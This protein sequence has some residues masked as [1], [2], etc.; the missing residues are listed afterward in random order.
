MNYMLILHWKIHFIPLRCLF[1]VNSLNRIYKYYWNSKKKV[2]LIL[3]SFVVN[4]NYVYTLIHHFYCIIF[5]LSFLV[6][7]MKLVS[8]TLES[9]FLIWRPRF[10]KIQNSSKHYQK[11]AEVVCILDIH[12][13]RIQFLSMKTCILIHKINHVS[14]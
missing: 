13:F 9:L 3:F 14:S 8:M 2:V 4:S 12:S 7:L 1:V 5:Q 11:I 6:K 10:R